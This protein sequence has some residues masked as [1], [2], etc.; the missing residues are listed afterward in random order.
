MELPLQSPTMTL[1]FFQILVFCSEVAHTLVPDADQVAKTLK[2]SHFDCGAMTENTFY[3]LNQVRQ[4]HITP[5]ELEVSQTK[6]ILYTKH[7]LKELNATESRIQHRREKWHSGHQDHSSIDHSIAGITSDLVISPEQCRSLA[8]GE[9]IYLDDQF[10]AVEYDTK[11]PIVKSDGSTSDSNRNHCN[12]RGWITRD[13][14]L[15]HMQRTTLKVRMSV[16]K[17]SSDSAQVLPCALEELGC[18]T[19]L[20]DSYAYIWDY[21]DNCVLSVLRTEDVNM[22]K[23]GT[24]Y[25][26]I[27]GPNSTTKLVYEVKNNPQKH[28]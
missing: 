3:A 10:L 5:E 17:V 18:E 25:Y 1:F 28:C 13:T 26:I 2:V 11:D 22:V 15:P 24:K 19:T 6:I 16:G 14:F 9:S 23:Q 4:C 21:P 7:F 8:I 20:L 12:V 27:S